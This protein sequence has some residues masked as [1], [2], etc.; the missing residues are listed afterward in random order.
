MDCRARA[1]HLWPGHGGR[2]D[3]DFIRLCIR[4]YWYGEWY[5]A[6]GGRTVAAGKLRGLGPDCTDGG[7]WYRDVDSYPQEDV[8]KKRIR[9]AQCVSNGQVSV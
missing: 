1:N 8:I 2:F 3:V 9:G 5:L 4:K 6:G 7:V